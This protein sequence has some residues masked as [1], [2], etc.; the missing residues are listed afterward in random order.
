MYGSTNLLVFGGGAIC[1]GQW[2]MESV[3]ETC[4]KTVIFAFPFG[5]AKIT[6]PLKTDVKI[7][8]PYFF[9]TLK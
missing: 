6:Q 5:G 9:M 1:F 4:L 3:W 8:C 7:V 2:Q